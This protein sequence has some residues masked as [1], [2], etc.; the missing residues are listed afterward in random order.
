MPSQANNPKYYLGFALIKDIGV[1]RFKQ[2]SYHFN[3]LEEAWQAPASEFMSA[4]INESLASQIALARSRINLEAEMEKLN[5]LKINLITLDDD[6]YP[7]LLKQIYDPPFT[8]FY[9]GTLNSIQDEFCLAVVGSRKF[10]SYGRQVTQNI[11]SNLAQN[12]ITIVSGLAL[13]IDSLA[14]QATLEAKGRTIAVMG[15][16]LDQIYPAVHY[17]LAQ[18][19]LESFGALISEYPPGTRPS[20]FTFPMRN[21]II[22]GLSLGTLIVEAGQK[23]GSLITAKTALDQNREVF[24]VPG[25]I[26]SL[27]SQG[28][29]Q[30]IQEGAKMI[31]SANDILETLNL[32]Q[33]IA[34]IESRQILPD[35]PEEAKI[36]SHLSQEPIQVDKLIQLSQLPSSQL[37]ATLTMMEIKGKIKNIGGNNYILAH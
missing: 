1:K 2:I 17:G 12:G 5:K 26:Y 37:N 33:A 20:K 18:K 31:T 34:Q 19:I 9:K 23:S 32:K 3:N 10:S 22:S 35:S 4:G 28:T 36:L 14:H 6:D 27:T 25:N 24:A 7:P 29:N 30:L 13:G 15:C 8:L 21:R 16:G 11:V